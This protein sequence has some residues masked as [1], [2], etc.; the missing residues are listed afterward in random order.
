[1]SKVLKLLA[2]TGDEMAVLS[3]HMQDAVL[4]LGDMT[5]Q[6]RRFIAV[7]NR[8]RWE[9]TR[10]NERVRSV[11]NVSGVL[12]VQRRNIKPQ[13]EGGVLSLLALHFTETDA[14]AGELAL[15]FAGGAELRLQVES[16]NAILEDITEAWATKSR[17]QHE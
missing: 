16:P 13:A 2:Q 8:F 14:P 7:M 4:Q 3:A 5:Y 12:A 15:I 9:N 10:T 11:L 6:G 1:M 17:P